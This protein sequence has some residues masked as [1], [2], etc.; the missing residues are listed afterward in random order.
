MCSITAQYA[1]SNKVAQLHPAPS[2]NRE[3]SPNIVIQDAEEGTKGGMKRRKQHRQETATTADDD[4]DINKQVGNSVV[5]HVM[6]LAGSHKRQ[7][8]PP[9]D[10]FQKLLEEICLNHTYPVKHKLKG[11]G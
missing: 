1:I 6:A 9:T 4:G 10:H 3:V 8:Q 5:V 11:Y 2:S 7:A